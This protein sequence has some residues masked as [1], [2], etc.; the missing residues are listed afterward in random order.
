MVPEPSTLAL[1]TLSLLILGPVLR[2]QA[3]AD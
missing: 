2:R 1:S 3:G